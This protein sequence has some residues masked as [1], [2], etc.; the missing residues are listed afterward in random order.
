MTHP[1]VAGV[2]KDVLAGYF[3]TYG[4]TFERVD[5]RTSR[6][7]FRGQ[8]GSFSVLVRTSQHWVVFSINPLMS[9]PD[10]G[11]GRATLHTLAAANHHVNM[12][13]LGIDSEDDIFLTVELPVEG[14]V[15]SHFADA[16]S[17]ISHTADQLFVPLLQARA[18][19]EQAL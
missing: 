14:F 17:A 10:C 9:P 16:L 7:G 11:W 18:I 12:V 13:K 15:Y 4:W 2:P 19:D 8:N 5:E 3:E 6:T 1:E